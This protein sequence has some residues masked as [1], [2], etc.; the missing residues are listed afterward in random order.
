[1]HHPLFCCIFFATEV[2]NPH[3]VQSINCA[4]TLDLSFFQ[5]IT[6]TSRMLAY[7]VLADY[8]MNVC[9]LEK[10]LQ[11]NLYKI[12]LKQWFQFIQTLT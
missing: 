6:A 11:Q 1:M 4:G 10:P 8:V 5:K 2:Y 9:G 12:L 3:L 7:G